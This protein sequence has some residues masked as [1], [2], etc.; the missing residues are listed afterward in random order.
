MV[1]L[2]GLKSRVT[3]TLVARVLRNVHPSNWKGSL[4]A[5]GCD[6]FVVNRV[7]SCFASC[8]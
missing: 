1:Y 7:P 4:D 2:T 8:K 6:G 5:D 3:Y